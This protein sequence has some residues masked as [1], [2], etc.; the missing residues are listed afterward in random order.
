MS[1]PDKKE[2]WK[3]ALELACPNLNN[4]FYSFYAYGKARVVYRLGEESRPPAWLE[5]RGFGLCVFEERKLAKRFCALNGQYSGLTYALLRCEA[6]ALHKPHPCVESEALG[7]GDI[8]MTS[9]TFPAGTRTAFRLTPVEIV[10]RYHAGRWG[11]KW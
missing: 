10:D 4:V 3:I 2:C 6:P 9:I 8:R 7:Y 11:V 5:E 1:N